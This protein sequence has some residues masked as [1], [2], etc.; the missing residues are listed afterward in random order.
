MAQE[1]N[2]IMNKLKQIFA[3]ATCFFGLLL[4][5]TGGGIEAEAS[6]DQWSSYNS[7]ALNAF[8]I[9]QYYFN[10]YFQMNR[11]EIPSDGSS[12]ITNIGLEQ[13][14]KDGLLMFAWEGIADHAYPSHVNSKITVQFING[15]FRVVKSGGSSAV[16][17]LFL[18]YIKDLS[19]LHNSY[20]EKYENRTPTQPKIY[21]KGNVVDIYVPYVYY[22]EEETLY[23]EK[24][25][26]NKLKVLTGKEFDAQF[27]WSKFS[28]VE[29][30]DN[31]YDT[32]YATNHGY[33]NKNIGNFLGQ[34]GIGHLISFNCVSLYTD[35]QY[36][37]NPDYIIVDYTLG[38]FLNTYASVWHGGITPY[39]QRVILGNLTWNLFYSAK[40]TRFIC[41]DY[42]LT[43]R[44]GKYLDVEPSEDYLGYYYNE[45]VKK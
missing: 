6:I 14:G 39:T 37:A 21:V 30:Y 7:D 12:I 43:L 26:E 3:C 17:N 45:G 36:M 10:D 41:T 27:R 29:K 19:G 15:E 2:D 1:R 16:D 23:I 42:T 25:F 35:G 11:W 33:F 4:A 13:L 32:N 24:Q 31:R 18:A 22:T 34:M 44:A 28:T 9:D 5:F 40:V 20:I 8:G 38:E